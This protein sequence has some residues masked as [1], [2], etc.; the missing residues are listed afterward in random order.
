MRLNKMSSQTILC[1]YNYS[2]IIEVEI[3]HCP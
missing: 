2:L 1:R 3:K